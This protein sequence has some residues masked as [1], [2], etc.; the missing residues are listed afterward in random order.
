MNRTM[1]VTVGCILCLLY[2]VCYYNCNYREVIVPELCH[3][4]YQ[5][6]ICVVACCQL[7]C[8]LVIGTCPLGFLSV[9]TI[10]GTLLLWRTRGRSAS[11]YL[12]SR[13]RCTWEPQIDR[14][15]EKVTIFELTGFYEKVINLI[16]ES[17]GLYEIVTNL[18]FELTG[19]YEKVTNLIFEL[20]A[21]YETVTHLI[22]ELTG[23][24][25]IVTNLI[26]KLPA[27]Y[28]K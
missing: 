9:R 28:E 22:F 20:T 13:T 25:E 1:Y 11:I 26:F 23:F 4:Q 8:P 16:F 14:F 18:L 2:Y 19:F 3:S 27:F 24:Y 12:K 10:W 6:H 5:R 17:T 21:F 15:Y 7:L